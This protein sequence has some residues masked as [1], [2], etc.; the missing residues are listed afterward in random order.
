[1]LNLK[2]YIARTDGVNPATGQKHHIARFHGQMMKTFGYGAVPHFA[3]EV[4]T[5]D[6]ALETHK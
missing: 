2:N 1:L 5:C 6:T 4:P 3:L